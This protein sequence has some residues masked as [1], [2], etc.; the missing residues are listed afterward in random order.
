MGAIAT[1]SAMPTSAGLTSESSPSIVAFSL[2]R[3]RR[4]FKTLEECPGLDPGEEAGRLSLQEV[5]GE[6]ERRGQEIRRLLLEAHMVQRGARVVGPAEESTGVGVSQGNGEP[7]VLEAVQAFEVFS[8]AQTSAVLEFDVKIEESLKKIMELRDKRFLIHNAQELERLEK[9]INEVTDKLAGAILAKRVQESLDTLEFK[10]EIVKLVKSFT[11]KIKNQGKRE[12]VIKPLRGESFKLS[13]SYFS[14]KEKKRNKIK[15][16]RAGFYPGLILLGIYDHCTPTLASEVSLTVVAMSSMDEAERTLNDRGIKLDIKTI[17]N[18]VLRYAE[19][20]KAAQRACPGL[21][22]GIQGYQFGETLSGRRVVISTDGGRIRIRKD[23]RGPKTEKGRR[24]YSTKWREPKLLIIYVVN[25]EGKMER[26]I[27]PFIDGVMRGPDAIFRLL[28]YYLSGMEIK[29]V[30]RILF[31]ADGARWIWNR[32]PKLMMDLEL[33]SNQVFEL[34]DFYHAVE[35]LGKVAACRKSWKSSERKRWLSKHIQMLKDG[36]IDQVIEAIKGLCHGRNSKGFRREQNYFE[37]N[38]HRMAYDLAVNMKL[39]IGSGAIESA[40]RRVVNLRLKGA[41]IFWHVDNAEAMLLLRSY[42]KSG[43][44]DM[45]KNLA[46]S[47]S[48]PLAA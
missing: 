12:V 4:E 27:A 8:P 11:K 47:P 7:Q 43:R 33:R 10:E 20:A 28:G 9:E 25:E 30:D 23:K 39:P 46:N 41:G 6:L 42:F 14:Q 29:N 1:L 48:L 24:R 18:I 31:I 13:T 2:A 17:R 19:R 3:A 15:K 32:V 21:D 35:H 16:K 40:I 5:E 34:I 38:R 36:K 44:W 26:E 37:R 22:P 45:L